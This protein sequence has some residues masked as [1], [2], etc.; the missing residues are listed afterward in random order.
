[1]TW[2]DIEK[3]AR[4]GGLRPPQFEDSPLTRWG[5]GSVSEPTMLALNCREKR[6][7]QAKTLSSGPRLTRRG[8][9]PQDRSRAKDGVE[10]EHSA[11]CMPAAPWG[12][13]VLPR[14]AALPF[15]STG[16]WWTGALT[17]SR[18]APTPTSFFLFGGTIYGITWP[19][20]APIGKRGCRTN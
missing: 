9:I 12:S 1:V 2:E 14:A 4:D 17:F 3:V 19:L 11:R 13:R 15:A 7:P 16:G 10:T 8:A 5:V 18:C 6:S 20:F